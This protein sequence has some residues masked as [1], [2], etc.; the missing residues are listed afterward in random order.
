MRVRV[1]AGLPVPGADCRFCIKREQSLLSR[2]AAFSIVC[3]TIS[4]VLNFGITWGVKNNPD[5]QAAPQTN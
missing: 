3:G 1:K 4:V 2:I 5:P